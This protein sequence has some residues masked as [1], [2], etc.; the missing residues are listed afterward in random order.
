MIELNADY[1]T[2]SYVVHQAIEATL[3]TW[4]RTKPTL[5]N[6]RVVLE[7]HSRTL[8]ASKEKDSPS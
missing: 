5:A 4:V 1:V 3:N 6:A 8:K 7:N 2:I